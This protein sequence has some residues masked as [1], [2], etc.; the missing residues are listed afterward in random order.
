MDLPVH[1]PDDVI[2]PFFFEQ[3]VLLSLLAGI[4]AVDDRAGW[5]SLL[6]HPVFASLLVAAI[7]GS[8]EAALYTGVALELVW[9]SILPMRGTRR[10]DTAT[11]GVVGI[12]TV[13]LIL[14]HTA[15]P[16]VTFII[17]TGVVMGLIAGE[18]TGIAGRF[19]NRIRE[20]R[21]GKFKLPEG[22][23]LGAVTCRLTVYHYLSVSYHAITSA[24]LAFAGLSLSVALSDR[25]TATFSPALVSGSSWW[26]YV[27][28]AIGA[29]GLA[30]NFWHKHLNRFLVLSAGIVLVILWIR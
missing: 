3:T 22:A 5:Q 1:D 7:A 21:L 9:I 20:N 17:A 11:G 16:R 26:L 14:R 19:L 18:A 12:G 8:W 2:T 15:D 25:L 29:A 30:Q 6:A 24:I 10:P 28:P 27:L 4:L 13:C 23:G